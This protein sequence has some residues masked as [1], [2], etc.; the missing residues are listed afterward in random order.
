MAEHR[1]AP[2]DPAPDFGLADAGGNRVS[3]S[4]LRGRRVI[5]YF[6]LAAMTP[7]STAQACDF[8]DDSRSDLSDAG[9]TV[10][11]IS[12]ERAYYGV[13]ATGHVARRRQALG[14]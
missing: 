4:S 12:I 9:F 2:G 7:G 10:R 11:G 5:V 8:R 14:V 13:K 3:L 6:Y 1:L